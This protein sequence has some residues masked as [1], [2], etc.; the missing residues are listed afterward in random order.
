MVRHLIR[1]VVKRGER[2]QF[3]AAAQAVS[4][5]AAASGH[6]LPRYRLYTS[7][8]GD[9]GEVWAEADY[10]SVDANVRVL[11]TAPEAVRIAIHTLNTHTVEGASHDYILE[12]EQVG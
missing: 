7:L 11:A 12:E 5:A 1:Y 9:F 2:K 4:D 10:E 8:F 6:P 3:L